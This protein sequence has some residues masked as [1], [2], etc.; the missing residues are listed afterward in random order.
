M[1]LR[2]KIDGEDKEIILLFSLSGFYGHLVT[3]LTYK[4]HTINLNVITTVLLSHSQRRL[5]VEEGTQGDG[6]YVKEGRDCKR[7]RVGSGNKRSKSRD[8]KI[9][10]C[11]SCKQIRHWEMDYPN[12]KHDLSRSVNLVHYIQV[13]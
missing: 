6:L 13:R 9:T 10:E 4:K 8:S 1:R 5:S 3:T 7:P 2:V 12:R 11:Y